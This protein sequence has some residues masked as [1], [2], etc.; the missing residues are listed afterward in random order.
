MIGVMVSDV[1]CETVTHFFVSTLFQNVIITDDQGRMIAEFCCDRW[2]QFVW[3]HDSRKFTVADAV[4]IMRAES[5]TPRL[6][7]PDVKQSSRFRLVPRLDARNRVVGVDFRNEAER[8]PIRAQGLVMAGGFGRRLGDLTKNLPKP[9]LHIGDRP[10]AEHL[11]ENLV[12]SGVED[13]FMSVHY[14]KDALMDHFGEGRK[15]GARVRYVHEDKPLG[16]GGCLSLISKEITDP[17][18]VVNGDIYTDLQFHRLIDYHN[19]SGSDI[20]ITVKRHA[21]AVPYGVIEADDVGNFVMREK[22]TFSYAINAAIYVLSPNVFK[23]LEYGVKIDMPTLIQHLVSLG[24]TVSLFPLMET[25]IDIGTVPELNR[26]R[27]LAEAR[28]KQQPR[29]V[30]HDYL[31][32]ACA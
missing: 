21:V 28:P 9:M 16:T 5:A 7:F 12:D 32:R 31:T 17:L 23:H 8:Q 6:M 13:I 2:R 4:K 29:D 27:L 14:C 3:E 15:V 26:A 30:L 20:T 1:P 25:W 24:A 11:V 18:I 10:I 22:P 19:A